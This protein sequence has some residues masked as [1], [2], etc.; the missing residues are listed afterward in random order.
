M[1]CGVML[2]L[3]RRATVTLETSSDLR[4]KTNA[5]CLLH[6]ALEHSKGNIAKVITQSVETFSW[7]TTFA[8]QKLDNCTLRNV[9]I[10]LLL[11]NRDNN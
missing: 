8:N 1:F 6:C 11:T 10:R 3:G 2:L 7:F 5:I 9:D 4:R